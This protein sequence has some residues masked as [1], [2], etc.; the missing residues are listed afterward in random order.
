[1][2][3]KTEIIEALQISVSIAKDAL[4]I[5]LADNV[6]LKVENVGLS[7]QIDRQAILL[8]SFQNKYDS[9]LDLY[10]QT[11]EERYTSENGV[12]LSEVNKPRTYFEIASSEPICA[13]NATE[14]AHY[15]SVNK[16][17]VMDVHLVDSDNEY[18][19]LKCRTGSFTRGGK[20]DKNDKLRSLFTTAEMIEMGY[21]I[22]DV[23]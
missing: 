9:L 7:V 23:E 18:Y 10:E 13:F 11:K 15:L 3:R 17:L 16:G 14:A 19:P 5:K 21:E 1:M 20:Y 6:R 22:P 8:E 2:G 4:A 12:I